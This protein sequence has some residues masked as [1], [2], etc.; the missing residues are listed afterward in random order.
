L[1]PQTLAQQI[2]QE[3]PPTYRYIAGNTCCQFNFSAYPQ[4]SAACVSALNDMYNA[5][6]NATVSVNLYDIY[7]PC[8]GGPQGY[9]PCLGDGH[10]PTLLDNPVFRRAIHAAPLSLIGG[11]VDCTT[12]LNYTSN[13]Y[14]LPVQVYTPLL[15]K[16]PSLRVLIYSGDADAC[17]PTAGT[18]K[19][20]RSIGGPVVTPWQ[21][22]ALDDQV[23]GYYVKYQKLSFLTVKGAGHLV[24]NTA[25]NRALRM[26]QMYLNDDFPA[27]QAS[28]T[29]RKRREKGFRA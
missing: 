7:G 29:A 1:I 6:G 11:W 5:F 13:Y 4:Q 8:V 14:D 18:E 26:F 23:A 2:E 19:W 28:H 17:V 10:L 16:M 15:Q 3:C 27:Q 21:F 20:T 9:S 24:P 25:P 22:W 12:R